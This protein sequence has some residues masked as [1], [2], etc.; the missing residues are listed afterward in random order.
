[1]SQSDRNISAICAALK[2]AASR[3]REAGMDAH[4]AKPLDPDALAHMLAHRFG[5]AVVGAAPQE[6]RP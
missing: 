3:C 1:M 6:V 5:F 2:G 4:L